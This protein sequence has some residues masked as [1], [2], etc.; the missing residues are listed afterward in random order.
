VVQ[1]KFIRKLAERGARI[2]LV[3]TGGSPI[4]LGEII[5][6]VEAILF[7]WYPGQEGGRAV[8]SLL[9]GDTSPSG[10][11]TIT[12]PEATADLPPFE[13]YSMVGR[14]YRYATREP[15]FPFGF[16]L[17]YASFEYRDLKITPP[18]DPTTGF[19]VAVTL[20]NTG[21]VAADEVVQLY[22][23]AIETRLPAPVSQLIAF[24]RVSLKPGQ[25]KKIR[26]YITP[27]MLMLVDEDGR[28]TLEPGKYKLTAGGCSP[29]ARG[30]EL[31]ASQPVSG[32]FRIS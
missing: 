1:R 5:D 21:S 24:Q 22:I 2:I 26:F 28:Y 12:F 11:L 20:K 30:V 15:L 7:V 17:T 13:D 9:F 4:A 3:L 18:I 16:G 6:M 25:I 14:T 23:S 29:G 32:E 27:E 8:A 31:G 19:W 10:K